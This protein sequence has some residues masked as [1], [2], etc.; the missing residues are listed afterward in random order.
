MIFRHFLLNTNEANAYI[1]A[2][3]AT[4]EAMFVDIG[5]FHPGMAD[6]VAE[7]NLNLTK[8]F[9]THDHYDHT[10]GLREVLRTYDAQVIAAKPLIEGQRTT[11]VSHG[12]TVSV[13]NLV[14]NVVST[15]GHTP[16]GLSLIFPGHIFSGDALFCGS[17][18]GTTSPSLMQEQI[19]HIRQNLF[20]KPGSF[21]IHSGHGPATTVAIER[22]CNPFFS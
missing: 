5:D 12:D 8:I 1:V 11:T 19:R 20:D 17:I 15:P 6:L 4:R 10:S 9:I 3:E 14:G 2:C 13:G 22:D 7:R 18:G 16:D 21:E